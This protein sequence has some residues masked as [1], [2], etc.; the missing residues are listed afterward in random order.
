MNFRHFTDAQAPF[1]DAVLAELRAGQKQSHWMWF[2]FPQLRALGRSPTALRY[3]I[4]DLEEARAYLR[5]P[6]LGARLYECTGLV[7]AVGARAAEVDTG[8]A[9]R[10]RDHSETGK[11]AH[12]IFGSPDDLKFRSSMTLFLKAAEAEGLDAAPFRM[13]LVRFYGGE[14]DPLTLALLEA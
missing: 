12:A 13:A 5:H 2:I 9:V 7:N 6:V 10:E 11:S 14:P 4:A 8:S 3:G 1:Y